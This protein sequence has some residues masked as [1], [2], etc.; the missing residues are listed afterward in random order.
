MSVEVVVVDLLGIH[1]P[2]TA[3]LFLALLA[4]HVA[5]AMVAVA[6]GAAAALTRRKGRGRHASLGTV[7]FTAIC[8]VF[9]TA[10]G[11]AVMRWR[12][13]YH[14]FL[15][16]AVAFAC[17]TI[18]VLARRRHWPGDTAHIAGMGGSY[19]A[20]LTAFYVDN[21]KQLPVWDRLPSIAYWLLPAAVGVPLIWRAIRRARHRP[22]TGEA[23][24]GDG[25]PAGGQAT[26]PGYQARERHQPEQDPGKA[27][28]VADRA[29]W[30]QCQREDHEQGELEEREETFHEREHAGA[31]LRFRPV[32]DEQDEQGGR[33]GEPRGEEEPAE[34]PRVAPHR[35]VRDGQEDAGVA[36]DEQAEGG[37]DDVPD[38]A[39]GPVR[40]LA[41][42]TQQRRDHIGAARQAGEEEVEEDVPGPVRRAGEM[43]GGGERHHP[44]PP[45]GSGG[46]SGG[47]GR[48][49]RSAIS[50]PSTPSTA[51]T[52]P[53]I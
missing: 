20:M 38:L 19:V 13:D 46:V 21:G 6:S 11:L 4:A 48:R 52:T 24:A 40:R 32:P 30:D 39:R 45:S 1:V 42:V 53:V 27:E 51:V 41:P 8:V 47:A 44:S 37:P 14:L 29:G 34:R 18:G 3:P 2:S 49:R 26:E 5:A 23:L 43:L 35:L 33:A 15:I 17:A 28:G 50:P 7:Y 31:G 9:A 16:G 10:T 22:L 25:E 36:G 12:Q